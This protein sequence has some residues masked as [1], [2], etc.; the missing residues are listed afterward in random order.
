MYSFFISAATINK[1]I[2]IMLTGVFG[3]FLV[4]ILF[5][6]LIKLL[7]KVLPYKE[8]EEDKT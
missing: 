5:F 8:S 2:I 4:L 7:M 3:V 1:S 6:F